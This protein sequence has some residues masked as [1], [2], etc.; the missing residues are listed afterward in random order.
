MLK[1]A[2]H[3]N[4]AAAA[5]TAASAIRI[6]SLEPLSNLRTILTSKQYQANLI[7]LNAI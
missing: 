6:G 7:V 2:V 1:A 3:H 4:N 5:I